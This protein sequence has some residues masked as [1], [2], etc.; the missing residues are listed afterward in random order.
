VVLLRGLRQLL[1]AATGAALIVASGAGHAILYKWVDEKGN[2]HYGENAPPGVR[3]Q[4]VAPPE[5]QPAR[6][7]TLEEQEREF[8]KRRLERLEREKAAQEKPGPPPPASGPP[9]HSPVT[10]QYLV[11]TRMAI[12]YEMR[13]PILAGTVKITVRARRENPAE[14]WVLPVYDLPPTGTRDTGLVDNPDPDT[15]EF[16][17]DRP[18]RLAPNDEIALASPVAEHFRC[19]PYFV[20]VQVFSD[21]R[22]RELI[23]EHRQGI[24]S[25]LN[26]MRIRSDEA[27]RDALRS[28]APCAP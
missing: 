28:T 5:P 26:G 22:G 21:S 1:A 6:P 23:G 25:R 2:V 13:A 4:E 3:A 15:Q 12:D 11:T 24:D 9:R 14:V 7:K 19:R 17:A 10:S 8:Q 27:L 16:A 20:T 18:L